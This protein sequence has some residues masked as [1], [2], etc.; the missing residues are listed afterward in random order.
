MA[1]WGISCKDVLDV[2]LTARHI[3]VILEGLSI[4]PM[5]GLRT[6]PVEEGS[7]LLSLFCM[8]F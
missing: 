4:R 6:D 7:K 5:V 1:I 8:V 2:V 3:R